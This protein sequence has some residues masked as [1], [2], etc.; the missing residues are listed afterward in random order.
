M[1]LGQIDTLG[2]PLFAY[3]APTGYPEDSRKWVSKRRIIARLNFA[4]R[5]ATGACPM[6][7]S[8]AP[9]RKR[10]GA[11]QGAGPPVETTARRRRRDVARHARHVLKQAGDAPTDANSAAA[12]TTHGHAPDR[13]RSRLARVPA[14]LR[15]GRRNYAGFAASGLRVARHGGDAAIQ[16]WR[17]VR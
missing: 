14:S 3:Q 11:G 16:Q 10:D 12:D 15:W 17:F 1:L 7:A 9:D 8:T 6:C 4:L 2:Q 5:L 13:P